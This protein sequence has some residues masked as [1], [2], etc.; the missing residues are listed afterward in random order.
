MTGAGVESS[1]S[2]ATTASSASATFGDF[3]EEINMLL[4]QIQCLPENAQIGDEAA[5]GVDA[6]CFRAMDHEAVDGSVVGSWSCCSNPGV[7]SGYN[8][9]RWSFADM[10]YY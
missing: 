6:C 9:K 7:D 4:R 2:T 10:H 8:Q 1:S 3:D 5:D